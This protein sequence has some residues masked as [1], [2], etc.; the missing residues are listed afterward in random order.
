MSYRVY[1]GQLIIFV[2][3]HNGDICT[4]SIAAEAFSGL[5]KLFAPELR[6]SFF[7][8]LKDTYY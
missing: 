1:D 8:C 4:A 5:P 2:L 7:V 6:L 3:T